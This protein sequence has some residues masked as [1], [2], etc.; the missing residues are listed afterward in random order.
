MHKNSSSDVIIIG[1]GPAGLSCARALAGVGLSIR[2]FDK[3]VGSEL[4]TPAYD[5]REIALT[6]LSREIMERL[7]LWHNVAADEIYP[8]RDARVLDGG[9][10]LQLHFPQPSRARGKPAD[11]LGFLISNHNIRRAAYLAAA[12]QPDVDIL[13]GHGVESVAVEADGVHVT[14]DDGSQYES[15]LVIAADSRFSPAR[16]QLGI[17]ADMHDFG[18]TVVVFRTRH[19]L[20]NEHTAFECFHYGRT[21]ALLPLEE[22][23]TNCVVTLDSQL[24]E[25]FLALDDAALAA[26]ME[27]LMDGRLGKM[28]IA[29]TRHSYPL[30]G[31]HARRF[32]GRRCALVGDAAVGM[33]PVTAHGFNLGIKSADLLARL[34]VNAHRAGRDIASPRLLE[35]YTARHMLSTRPLYH[36]TNFVVKLFT[37]ETPPAK[38]L[39]QFVLRASDHLAPV[40]KLISH[41]LTG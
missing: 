25:D 36:G 17:P 15:R 4:E 41:Q 14:L 5:G 2:I 38:L 26:D 19:T 28:E 7:D 34:V 37:N 21:L 30:V 29:S 10:A 11:S 8:L 35:Q 16:H 20:S 27:E 13:A 3:S 31:V 32:H 22:N 24:A 40:K 9:S 33:H 1:A 6:H 39:R 18:R 23:M 12:A